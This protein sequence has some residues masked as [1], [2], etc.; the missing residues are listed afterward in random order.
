LQGTNTHVEN[1]SNLVST[2][3]SFDEVLYL[4]KPFWRKPYW[5]SKGRASLPLN[6]LLIGH[7]LTP[8]T[9]FHASTVSS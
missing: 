8:H 4:L 9:R 3:S 6:C 5:F 7:R 1:I 2:F